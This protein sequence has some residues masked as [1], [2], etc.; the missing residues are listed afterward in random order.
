MRQPSPRGVTDET[1]QQTIA[2]N[3]SVQRKTLLVSRASHFLIGHSCLPL[4]WKAVH[5]LRNKPI[6]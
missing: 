5:F 2:C 3:L 4:R 6:H 1:Q